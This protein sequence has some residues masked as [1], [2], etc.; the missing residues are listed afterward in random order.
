MRGAIVKVSYEFLE[1]ALR[2]CPE[3]KLPEDIRVAIVVQEVED[4]LRHQFS[5]ILLSETFPDTPEGLTFPFY[6]PTGTLWKPFAEY[7]EREKE[8]IR[9]LTAEMSDL[10]GKKLVPLHPLTFYEE[11]EE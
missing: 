9:Q 5:V 7:G 1:S 8:R 3:L 10:A 2:Q 4:G 6:D 11:G